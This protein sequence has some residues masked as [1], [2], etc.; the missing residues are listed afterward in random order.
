ML[1]LKDKEVDGTRFSNAFLKL[2]VSYL[3]WDSP[4]A[5]HNSEQ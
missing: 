4:N 1:I 2:N 3:S 5:R